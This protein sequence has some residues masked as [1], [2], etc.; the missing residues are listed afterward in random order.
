MFSNDFI[1][2]ASFF[3]KHVSNKISTGRIA[4][5]DT[6]H[7]VLTL[8][9]GLEHLLKGVIYDINPLYIL[10]QPDFKNSAR[11]VYQQKILPQAATSKNIIDA[12]KVDCDVITMRTSIVRAQH[13]SAATYKHKGLLYEINEARDIIAHHNLKL[14]DKSKLKMLLLRDTYQVI[15]DF[16]DEI[17]IAPIHLFNGKEFKLRDI[18]AKH[19]QSL[20]ERIK[21]LSKN[22]K[23]KYDMLIRNAGYIEDKQKVTQEVSRL[24]GKIKVPCPVCDNDALLFVSEAAEDLENLDNESAFNLQITK[25][26]CY[27]CKLEFDD[28]ASIDHLKLYNKLQD[29]LPNT[30]IPC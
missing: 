7:V 14:L 16:V 9:L 15:Q 8:S 13:F 4:E 1:A 29:I 6:V 24:P 25:I 30:P 20:E 28:Y 18:A 26:K 5:D 11:S 19:V 27:Y 17:N 21:L 22:W 10:L 23:E 2:D 3:L 12:D